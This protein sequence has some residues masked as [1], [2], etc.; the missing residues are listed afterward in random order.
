M[1]YGRFTRNVTRGNLAEITATPSRIRQNQAMVVTPMAN[2]PGFKLTGKRRKL[3]KSSFKCHYTDCFFQDA[4]LFFILLVTPAGSFLGQVVG[5]FYLRFWQQLRKS[6]KS[7]K[8][9][10]P[11][12][13]ANFLNLLANIT[14]KTALFQYKL[15][16]K[17]NYSR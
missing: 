1:S 10:H 8:T 16:L 13:L 9:F 15:Q 11:C 2:S 5:S 7:A 17:Q 6:R 4:L 12:M 3:S 14:T